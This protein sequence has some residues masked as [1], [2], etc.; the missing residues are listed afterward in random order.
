MWRLLLFLLPTR[1]RISRQLASR[2]HQLATPG[3]TS[4]KI[5]DI[6]D[7]CLIRYT[8]KYLPRPPT[9]KTCLY[10]DAHRVS[11]R[12]AQRALACRYCQFQNAAT[13]QEAC[14]Y[15]NIDHVAL[16][17]ITI[18]SIS[19][20]IIYA[21]SRLSCSRQCRAQSPATALPSVEGAQSAF[22]RLGIMILQLMLRYS[23][24]TSFAQPSR[25]HVGPISGE[26]QDDCQWA[27]QRLE[28]SICNTLHSTTSAQAQ[29]STIKAPDV[30]FFSKPGALMD[31]A[32]MIIV[33]STIS[34]RL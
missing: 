13:V 21:G 31:D 7:T 15:A 2:M 19:R 12:S 20:R 5:A 30:A 14:P 17:A 33:N 1:C 32:D 27:S 10:R 26:F 25:F 18:A 4:Y 6:L 29:A 34:G 23:M 3:Y 28:I 16:I 24:S 11:A 8:D 22:P 9:T